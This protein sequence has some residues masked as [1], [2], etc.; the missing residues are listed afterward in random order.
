[1]ASNNSPMTDH[2]QI[3]RYGTIS[4]L[5]QNEP[6]VA[7]TSFGIDS[8]TLTFGRDKDCSIRLF[9]Q[10][11]DPVHCKINFRDRKAFL[12]VLGSSGL[13]IDGCKAYP[14]SATGS[15]ITIP[16]LNDSV[17]EI[18]GK[19]FRFTYPPKEMRA[20]L[21][22]TPPQPNRRALRLSMI[23]S[24][25][26]FTPRP[27]SNPMENLR[28]LQSPLRPSFRSRS[29]TPSP[30]PLQTRSLFGNT[31][32]S[33]PHN[34]DD[35]DEPIVLVNGDNPRVVE[36]DKD[37]VIL[38][39][40][41]VSPEQS[42][43]RPVSP[44]KNAYVPAPPMLSLHVPPAPPVT[45]RRSRPSL[46]RAVLIRSAQRAVL[47]AREEE[48]EEEEEMEVFGTIFAEEDEEEDEDDQ[49]VPTAANEDE[50]M[51]NDDDDEETND[52]EAQQADS[53]SLWRKSLGRVWPFTSRS[54][55][56]TKDTTS[57]PKSPEAPVHDVDAEDGAEEPPT[58]DPVMDIDADEDKE[59]DEEEAQENI[60][61]LRVIAGT[62][63]RKSTS[64]SSQPPLRGL[65]MTPQPQ[66]SSSS[67]NPAARRERMSL[68]GQAM[69]IKVEEKPWKVEDIVLPGPPAAS[70]SSSSTTSTT[71]T[72]KS[73]TPAPAPVPATPN[74]LSEAERAAIRERRR[75]ALKM[76]FGGIPGLGNGPSSS[77]T[78][79]DVS[80]QPLSSPFKARRTGAGTGTE[81]SI[82]ESKEKEDDGADAR[83]LL[84][85][86]KGAVEEMKSRRASMG[87]GMSPVKPSDDGKDIEERTTT[88]TT[89]PTTEQEQFSLLRTPD[90]RRLPVPRRSIYVLDPPRGGA[91]EVDS[92]SP[93]KTVPEKEA[94]AQDEDVKMLPPPPPALKSPIKT[95]TRTTTVD[96][97]SLADD[98]ASPA[99]A[100]AGK[101]QHGGESSEENGEKEKPKAKV[102]TGRGKKVEE[103]TKPPSKTQTKRSKTP[104]AADEEEDSAPAPAPAKPTKPASTSRTRSKTPVAAVAEPARTTRRAR[105]AEPESTVPKKP[106]TATRRAGSAIPTPT[107]A[108]APRATR[109]GATTATSESESEVPTTKTRARTGRKKVTEEKEKEK[110]KDDDDDPLE[111]EM[112][113][114]TPAPA[115]APAKPAA[116]R[117]RPAKAAAAVVPPAIK[118][119]ET[120]VGGPA[121]AKTTRSKKTALGTE[122]DNLPAAATTT[123]TTKSRGAKSSKVVEP[124][125]VDDKENS[126]NEVVVTVAKTRSVAATRTTRKT[127]TKTKVKE[128]AVTEPELGA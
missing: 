108:P 106:T 56:P 53:G 27:S 13:V 91:M 93:T 7:V 41:E 77:P 85:R 116:K 64:A 70:S 60:G 15:P 122:A 121:K 63:I 43:K 125:E 12:V 79:R 110:E 96:T 88:T 94:A 34:L 61:P 1:M 81:E 75:S 62:P 38:E 11:V 100:G 105:T 3:G 58:S 113:E 107:P 124:E 20:Q 29:V 49:R 21:Y 69:R 97:P 65:F 10:D 31:A 23:H 26:V 45:P 111:K 128:E 118:E 46:H 25:E 59:E 115:P 47:K 44:T 57:P 102:M 54:P 67:F 37:L 74:R 112:E 28:V 5:K 117:G 8:E 82:P 101:D 123:T 48:E 98:E 109:R 73:T 104:V 87:V 16:L 71:S 80:E 24:A 114:P 52:E 119:E 89:T 84:E 14:G 78:K 9:Y 72:T 19:R 2:T 86:M 22:D 51:F 30:S 127:T 50:D 90:A 95:R 120:D 36:E 99:G 33:G 126:D 92:S 4:L 55:S 42:T 32:Q 83:T 39:D 76:P 40:V 103:S 17:I 66:S 18:H 35:E 6:N 68:G